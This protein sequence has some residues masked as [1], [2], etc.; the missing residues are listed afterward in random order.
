MLEI[1]HF[2]NIYIPEKAVLL[3]LGYIPSKAKLT[4]NFLSILKEEI[5]FAKK[6]IVP[7]KIIV[8]STIKII[9]EKNL[10]LDNELKI[11]SKN[12]VLLLKNC[13]KAY[14]FAVTLGKHLEEKRDYYLNKKET[15]RALI[16]DAIGSVVVEELA[17]I[18]NKEIIKNCEKENLKTT[19][20]FSPG[21]GDWNL[22]QQKEFLNFLQLEKI[23][24]KL[25]KNF[26][27]Q[28]EK[29]ISAILGAYPKEL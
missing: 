6:I 20:R 14:S 27:M 8:S 28:P 15:S 18:V 26:I 12:I 16:L 19:K 22:K 21:Y 2:K 4:K 25:T 9:D 13:I 10:L 1:S 11:K 5:K 23:K 7:Q 24:V 17:E 3:R 29:S